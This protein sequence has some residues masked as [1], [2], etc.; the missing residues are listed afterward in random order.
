M[1]NIRCFY[2][3]TLHLRYTKYDTYLLESTKIYYL[4]LNLR[5]LFI[6]KTIKVTSLFS[7]LY[8]FLMSSLYCKFNITF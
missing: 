5:E 3:V 7:I 8:I 4:E 2:L 6:K 1:I